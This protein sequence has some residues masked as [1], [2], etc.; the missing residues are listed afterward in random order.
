MQVF[1]SGSRTLLRQF[2]GHKA[3]VHV[4]RFAADQLH[5]LSGGDDG[6]LALWDVTSGHQ[7]GWFRRQ[8]QLCMCA[9]TSCW[10]AHF[11]HHWDVAP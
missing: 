6:L 2:K 5:V 4:A 3:P 11:L 7:V 8:Q 10:P 9:A 1:D